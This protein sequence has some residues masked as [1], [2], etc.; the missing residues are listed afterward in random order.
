MLR[1]RFLP[2]LILGLLLGVPAGV[3]VGLLVL[4][5]R[6]SDPTNPAAAQ[7]EELTRKL[8]LAKEGK[9]RVDR[10]LDQFQKLAEQM[11]ASFNTLEQRFK[12]LEEEQR[13]REARGGQPEPRAQEPRAPQPQAPSHAAVPDVSAPTPPPDAPPTLAVPPDTAAAQQPPAG[14]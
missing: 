10:Q 2:G 4:P 7:I 3:V 1:L 6:A 14:E 5:P 8:E 9:E 12:L 13:L 11:T